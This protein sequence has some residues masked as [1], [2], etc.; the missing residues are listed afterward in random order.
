MAVLLD[1]KSFQ[2][3]TQLALA[4][5]ALLRDSKAEPPKNRR[6][7]SAGDVR[8]GTYQKPFGRCPIKPVATAAKLGP[9]LPLGLSKQLSMAIACWAPGQAPDFGALSGRAAQ[10]GQK[11]QEGLLRALLQKRPSGMFRRTSST[12]VNAG[13]GKPALAWLG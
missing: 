11:K 12:G 1:L 7:R 9:G 10:K 5:T 8:K 13:T 6:L 3:A 2:I 4:L